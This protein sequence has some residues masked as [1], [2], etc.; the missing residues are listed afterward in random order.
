MS[1]REPEVYSDCIPV[2]SGSREQ[3]IEKSGARAAYYC[4]FRFPERVRW[5]G[6]YH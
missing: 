4:S 1:V 5:V 3:A 2:F 6:L